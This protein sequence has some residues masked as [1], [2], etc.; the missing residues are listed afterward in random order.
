MYPTLQFKDTPA[1]PN[2]E[3]AQGLLKTPSTVSQQRLT[4]KSYAQ[5]SVHL[6]AH[7]PFTPCFPIHTGVREGGLEGVLFFLNGCF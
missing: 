3:T 2:P 1:F 5:R 6:L 4:S 7:L